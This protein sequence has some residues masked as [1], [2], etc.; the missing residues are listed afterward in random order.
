MCWRA[1]DHASDWNDRSSKSDWKRPSYE[2]E[3]KRK[4]ILWLGRRRC[5]RRSCPRTSCASRRAQPRAP[6]TQ[7]RPRPKSRH[8]QPRAREN[9]PNS[10]HARSSG[11]A[12]LCFARERNPLRRTTTTRG[13][14]ALQKAENFLVAAV[15]KKNAPTMDATAAAAFV[16]AALRED[17]ALHAA[18]L[19]QLDDALTACAAAPNVRR[20]R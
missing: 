5:S 14:A 4:S 12:T 18:L 6:T 9:A 7:R 1:T 2:S 20:H 13:Q 15:R 10:E 16:A 8:T 19:G 11:F 17:N 3:T